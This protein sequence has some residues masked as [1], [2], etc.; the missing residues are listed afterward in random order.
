MVTSLA[1]FCAVLPFLDPDFRLSFPPF[2]HHRPSLLLFR[3]IITSTSIA[4]IRSTNP[5]T[6]VIPL[7]HIL[8]ASYLHHSSLFSGI[9]RHSL[10]TWF[11]PTNNQRIALFLILSRPTPAKARKGGREALEFGICDSIESNNPA[12]ANKLSSIIAFPVAFYSAS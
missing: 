12:E 3:L 5:F 7:L 1:L 9:R 11:H 10:V 2:F 4:V 6:P 8:I